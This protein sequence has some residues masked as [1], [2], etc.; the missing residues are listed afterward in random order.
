MPTYIIRKIDP[1]LWAKAK[2]RALDEDHSLRGIILTLVDL[3]TQ[4]G[5]EPLRQAA[6]VRSS[7]S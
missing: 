2:A 7:D 6:K 1:E 3:Y 5:L 4:V